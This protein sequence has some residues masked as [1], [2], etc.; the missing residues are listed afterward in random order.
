MDSC[1]FTDQLTCNGGHGPM[2]EPVF[3]AQSQS[4]VPPEF[5]RKWEI[6]HFRKFVP[7]EI[8]PTWELASTITFGRKKTT[9]ADYSAA[10]RD[11]LDC[12]GCL[13]IRKW[14]ALQDLNLRLPPCEDIAF[15]KTKDLAGSDGPTKAWS[16]TLRNSYWT[17]IWTRVSGIG[18]LNPCGCCWP[19]V[20]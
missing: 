1:S 14:W 6:P 5:P 15:Q 11:S 13:R 10:C 3:C 4:H 12:L 19:P 20:P 16:G 18:K 8:P 2:W 7:P 17:L 9:A